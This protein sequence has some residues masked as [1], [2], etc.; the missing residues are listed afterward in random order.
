MY[1][2]YSIYLYFRGYEQQEV[3]CNLNLRDKN[4]L[5]NVE[6]NYFPK[7]EF[8]LDKYL[9]FFFFALSSFFCSL[10]KSNK[11]YFI[12]AVPNVSFEV[13]APSFFERFIESHAVMLQG[14]A[15]LKPKEGEVTS[16]PWQWPINYRVIYNSFVH[17]VISLLQGLQVSGTR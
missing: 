10:Q 3:S 9:M 8:L 6:D 4:S 11:L 7:C 16:R 1:L 2:I 13:Y 5:W 17:F 12:F 15:G 14:N